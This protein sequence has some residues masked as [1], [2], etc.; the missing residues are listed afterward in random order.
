MKRQ[1][2]I[3]YIEH[4]LTFDIEDFSKQLNISS[5]KLDS[6]NTKDLKQQLIDN[7]SNII[8]LANSDPI[9]DD[10]DFN[11][12]LSKQHIAKICVFNAN[13]DI[14]KLYYILDHA[15]GDCLVYPYLI[16]ALALA[17][18]RCTMVTKLMEVNT[19]Q[20]ERL[21]R[22][23]REAK[24]SN[25]AYQLDL[26]AGRNLQQGMSP[27]SP[28]AFKHLKAEHRIIPSL[29]LSGDF[30]NYKAA[31]DRYFLF[32]LTDVAGHG[33][34]SA[35]VTVIIKE[36]MDRILRRHEKAK[37]HEKLS[38]TPEGFSEIINSNLINGGIEKHVTA[39]AGM[40][41]IE[42]NQLRL[43]IAGH[44]PAPIIVKD[45]HARFLES[46]GKPIGIFENEQWQV[47]VININESVFYCFSDGVYDVLPG[48]SISEKDS[49]L[50]AQLER[51]KPTQ[52]AV[53][54]A[55]N[56]DV[57]VEP[58]DDISLL[59]IDINTNG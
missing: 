59:I 41:D 25:N 49:Y 12:W 50:L 1:S 44:I 43:T 34:A 16:T 15:I 47:D 32:F 37:D 13:A 42:T 39:I 22:H 30:I 57:D 14:D 9:N 23:H 46:S 20:Y 6:T 26:I 11:Q 51:C 35:F 27:D 31:L 10:D 3:A 56:I 4:Q 54:D 21:K 28:F 45:G 33:S 48:V 7:E 52:E 29:Y 17:V 19:Y 53:F 5:T 18:R 8:V 2:K 24:K 38:Q 36:L 55:L 40:I 58:Q